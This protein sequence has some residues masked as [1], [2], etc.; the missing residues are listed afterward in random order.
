MPRTVCNPFT[1]AVE[2]IR[3]AVYGA[4]NLVSL[5]IVAGTAILAFIAAVAG[6]DP[7]R[8]LLRRRPGGG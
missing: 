8:G 4:L 2:L 5:G 3:F 1:D 6:Y 7:S